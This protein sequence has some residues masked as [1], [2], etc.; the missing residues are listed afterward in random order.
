M[1][2]NYRQ[3]RKQRENAKKV[4][5][6]QKEQRRTARLSATTPAPAVAAAE[7]DPVATSDV[8][9]PTES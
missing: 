6:Q 2:K 4:R 3:E 1:P 8:I 9:A 5:Q 7:G